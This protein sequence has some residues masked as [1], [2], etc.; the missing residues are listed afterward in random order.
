MSLEIT[1]FVLVFLCSC[2]SGFGN[3]WRYWALVL[4]VVGFSVI[5]PASKLFKRIGGRNLTLREGL[6]EMWHDQLA[7]KCLQS[8]RG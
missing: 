2:A 1:V 4:V 3:D 6:L 7:R 8:Q 5:W